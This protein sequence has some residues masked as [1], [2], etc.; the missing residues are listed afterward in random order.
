MRRRQ[1]G[2]T[3]L[4]AQRGETRRGGGGETDSYRVGVAGVQRFFL[5]GRHTRQIVL[6]KMCAAHV[7]ATPAGKLS[8]SSQPMGGAGRISGKSGKKT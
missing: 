5:H 3:I 7:R 4:R 2:E 1:I 8:R 6:F